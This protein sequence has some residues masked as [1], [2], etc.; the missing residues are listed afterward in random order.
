VASC[1]FKGHFFSLIIFFVTTLF[2]LCSIITRTYNDSNAFFW[3]CNKSVSISPPL[4][5]NMVSEPLPCLSIVQINWYF[6][7]YFDFDSHEG[8]HGTCLTLLSICYFMELK[9]MKQWGS[10]VKIM[11]EQTFEVQALCL[12]L[13]AE[14]NTWGNYFRYH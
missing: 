12:R 9:M 2:I 7:R 4:F 13:L 8:L 3:M 11:P 6:K 1:P 14:G 5:P 10:F